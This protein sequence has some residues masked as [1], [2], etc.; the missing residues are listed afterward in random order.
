MANFIIK[1]DG[2]KNRENQIL[3][4]FG[5]NPA[6]ASKEQMEKAEYIAEKTKELQKKWRD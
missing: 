4:E 3:K 1:N 5:C 2:R 6:A